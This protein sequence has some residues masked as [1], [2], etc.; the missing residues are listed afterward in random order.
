MNYK[1]KIAIQA[2]ISHGE[3]QWTFLIFEMLGVFSENPQD[4]GSSLD[5]H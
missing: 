4:Q 3:I 5:L 2:V 1:I